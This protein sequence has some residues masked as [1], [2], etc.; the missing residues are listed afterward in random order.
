LR[1][2]FWWIFK[3]SFI[4]LNFFSVSRWWNNIKR[5]QKVQF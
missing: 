3:W 2:L 1:L 4:S 5:R